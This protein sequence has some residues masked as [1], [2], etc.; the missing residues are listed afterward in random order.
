MARVLRFPLHKMR[1]TVVPSKHRRGLVVASLMLTSCASLLGLELDVHPYPAEGA[2]GEG[3]YAGAAS[4]E[5][6]VGGELAG[7]DNQ[8]G[9]DGGSAGDG[10]NGGAEATG[11]EDGGTAGYA[12]G[13]GQG[14]QP[15]NGLC[16][17][18]CAEDEACLTVVKNI[19]LSAAIETA[20]TPRACANHVKEPEETAIDCGSME[21]GRCD[22]A[23][24]R[25]L[26]K[27]GTAFP[28]VSYRRSVGDW[29]VSTYANEAS[30][31]IGRHPQPGD[32][33]VVGDFDGDKVL[34]YAAYNVI[35]T[36][37]SISTFVN[38][39]W[40]H[41]A[42]KKYAIGRSPYIPTVAHFDKTKVA[43]DLVL[44]HAF[45]GSWLVLSMDGTSKELP[46]KLG[47][48]FDKPV[49][50]DYDGDGIDELAVYSQGKWL[51]KRW[52][53]GT[54][55]LLP[56]FEADGGS[57]G[58]G[59]TGGGIPVPCHYDEDDKVDL[60]VFDG[61]KGTW[62]IIDGTGQH[63][64]K[65]TPRPLQG[66]LPVAGNFA[67]DARCDPTFWD[68]DAGTWRTYDLNG[69]VIVP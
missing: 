4:E 22:Q 9:G 7:A 68:P 6:G 65:L 69:N 3:G 30:P 42:A 44:F 26:R 13:G 54:D 57:G 15:S 10:G 46:V 24:Y 37:W 48:P 39:T 36:S 61:S 29:F 32:A 49:P 25:V 11:A 51:A 14:G 12:G 66:E 5:P 1:M 58:T 38:D 19:Q 23:P 20:C 40:S 2:G 64:I 43:D 35:D 56:E 17:K 33:P 60:G 67:Q 16:A 45:T 59:G 28:L 34:D 62:N 31:F 52:D 18:G 53:D 55:V 21:C 41:L 8:P 50:A 63:T 47:Q 27:P